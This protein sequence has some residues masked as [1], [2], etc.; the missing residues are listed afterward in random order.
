MT[1]GSDVSGSVSKGV[2]VSE[3]PRKNAAAS[4]GVKS[5]VRDA[6]FKDVIDALMALVLRVVEGVD[7][8]VGA[9]GGVP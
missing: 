4:L 7:G 2:A 6:E 8:V 1:A 5:A 9:G 3:R